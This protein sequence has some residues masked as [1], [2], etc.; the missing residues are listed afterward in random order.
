MEGESLASTLGQRLRA[1]FGDVEATPP[2][3]GVRTAA[4]L[5]PLFVRPRAV[6]DGAGGDVDV[7]DLRVLLTKRSSR[8]SSHSGETCFP[9]GHWEST[10]A[11][12]V[13]MVPV[14]QLSCRPVVD[15]RGV[16]TLQSRLRFVHSPRSRA[17][18]RR[19]GPD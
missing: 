4:V 8:L 1:A 12:L 16:T 14:P 5:V 17:G 15:R 18:R 7:E 19:S 2:P 13:C 3:A 10:D 11:S 6:A 9:G